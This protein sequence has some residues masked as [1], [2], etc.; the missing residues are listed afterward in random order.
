MRLTLFDLDGTLLPI[1]SDHAFGRALVRAGWADADDFER[2]NDVFYAD[3]LAERLDL[4][5]YVEFSTAPWRDRAEAEAHALRAR[6]IDEDIRPQLHAPAR[7]LVERHRAEGDLLAIVIATNEFVTRPIADLFAVE[8][9]LAIELERDARGRVTGALRGT[10][11]FREG[12]IDRVESW[13]R[14]LG[15]HRD[16]F[17][18]ITVYSD[19]MNDRPLLEWATHAVAT[20]PS[21][22]LE[23]LARERGWPVLRL[24]EAEQAQQQ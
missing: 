5:A 20:N 22:S 15:H 24:F 4:P 3:Y 8:H 1:D 19:S 13:L 9:L 14:A 11:T 2:R 16:D 21:A 18:R 10:P 6:Y 23:A 12:K 17:E 7:A